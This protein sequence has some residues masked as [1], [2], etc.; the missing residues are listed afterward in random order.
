MGYYLSMASALVG[1]V[2]LAIAIE[3]FRRASI[4]GDG[5]SALSGAGVPGIVVAW[6]LAFYARLA[7]SQKLSHAT[8]ALVQASLRIV[9]FIE[10]VAAGAASWI[11]LRS[12]IAGADLRGILLIADVLQI[13]T[14]LWVFRYFRT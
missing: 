10:I 11:V 1:L 8:Q 9:M 7:F 14:A 13:G 3:G 5:L 6:A 2:C 12:N 4:G